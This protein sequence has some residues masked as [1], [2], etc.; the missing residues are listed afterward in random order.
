MSIKLQEKKKKKRKKRKKKS[1]SRV[2]KREKK[3][4]LRSTEEGQI[5]NMKKFI[6][7]KNME[8]FDF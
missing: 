2:D 5:K 3:V 6:P 4:W 8:K 7:K 1:R